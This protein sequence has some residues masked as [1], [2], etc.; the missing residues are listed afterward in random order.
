MTVR[1]TFLE[2]EFYPCSLQEFID[3][4]GRAVKELALS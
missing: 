2:D 3:W 4:P 1:T